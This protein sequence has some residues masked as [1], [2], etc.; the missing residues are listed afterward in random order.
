MDPNAARQSPQQRKF[1]NH[2]LKIIILFRHQKAIAKHNDNNHQQQRHQQL[3][4]S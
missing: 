1:H 2:R 3:S 4:R